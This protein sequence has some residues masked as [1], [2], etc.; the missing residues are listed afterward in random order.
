MSEEKW[1]VQQDIGDV[2]KCKQ[3]WQYIR[4][5]KPRHGTAAPLKV[6]QFIDGKERQ[7][8]CFFSSSS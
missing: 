2:K 7:V 4:R 5:V 3:V 8:F 1:L 6:L